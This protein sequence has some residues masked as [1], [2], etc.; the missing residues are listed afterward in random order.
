[1]S[2]DLHFPATGE[3]ANRVCLFGCVKSDFFKLGGNRGTFNPS[4]LLVYYSV[5]VRFRGSKAPKCD[6]SLPLAMKSMID[7]EPSSPWSAC[8]TMIA[9]TSSCD[10]KPSTLPS[11][12]ARSSVLFPLPL[13][14]QTPYLLPRTRRRVVCERSNSAP[15][16]REKRVLTRTSSLPA[17]TGAAHVAY[18]RE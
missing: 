5:R 11:R 18:G 1:M 7:M 13:L 14:A 8:S 12:M 3:T 15:Y 9:R 16:A 6:E 2:T 4:E 17:S 10:G